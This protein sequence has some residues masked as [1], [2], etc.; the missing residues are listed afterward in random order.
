MDFYKKILILKQ[1]KIG[2]SSG[3]KE[4][5][6]VVRLEYEDGTSTL[7]LSLINFKFLERGEYYCAVHLENNPLEIFSL[8]KKPTSSIK[9]FSSHKPYCSFSVGIFAVSEEGLDNEVNLPLVAF[10]REGK[11]ASEDILSQAFSIKL[12]EERLRKNVEGCYN[13]EAVATENYYTLEEDITKKVDLING[14]NDEFNRD[15]AVN[16]YIECEKEEEKGKN[17]CNG[18][19]NEEDLK[20][21]KIYSGDNPYYLSAKNELE[22]LFNKFPKDESLSSILPNGRFCKIHY[23]KDKY[24]TVGTVME[25]GEV[26]YICYGVPANYS[27][28]P[29]KELKDYCS[30]VPLSLFNLQGEGFWMMFQ[31]AITGECVKKEEKLQS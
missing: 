13:D 20:E 27:P 2:F 9:S 11:G 30:F 10:A 25:R 15:E 12:S 28:E 21:S 17:Q 5:S 26:K 4:V 23:A 3:D 29:P 14:W 1:S 7:S 16:K 31:D 8:D 22:E 19:S 6:G 18:I 24:Y